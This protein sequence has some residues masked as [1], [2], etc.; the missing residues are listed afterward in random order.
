MC[1][2]VAKLPV[3]RDVSVRVH[4]AYSQKEWFFLVARLLQEC[5]GM[6]YEMGNVSSPA[7]FSYLPRVLTIWGNMNLPNDASLVAQI[8]ENPRRGFYI[9]VCLETVLFMG[10]ALGA[11]IVRMQTGIKGG[12]AST[13]RGSRRESEFEPSA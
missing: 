10:E 3:V 11:V 8:V 5:P 9:W 6:I 2:V 12:T 13:A 7:F 4:E 1:G